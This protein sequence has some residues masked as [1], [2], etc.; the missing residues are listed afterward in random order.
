MGVTPRTTSADVRRVSLTDISQ[1]L[2]NFEDTN[3]LL[4]LCEVLGAQ[5]T[6]QR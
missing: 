2:G 4:H 3:S 5:Q 6:P 1:R